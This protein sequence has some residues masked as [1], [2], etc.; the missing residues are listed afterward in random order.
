MRE[1]RRGAPGTE[2]RSRSRIRDRSGY[3]CLIET[4]TRAPNLSLKLPR[5]RP[6]PPCSGSGYQGY[7]RP[8]YSAQRTTT[9]PAPASAPD[10]RLRPRFWLLLPLLFLPLFPFRL[11]LP[12]RSCPCSRSGSC[13]RSGP[14]FGGPAS[15][16]LRLSQLSIISPR[17]STPPGR[18]HRRAGAL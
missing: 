5:H 15:A 7:A 18:H 9:P 16:I 1:E 2:D 3:A 10:G 14:A 17:R 12:L 4:D 11:L 13:S 6:P 8:M